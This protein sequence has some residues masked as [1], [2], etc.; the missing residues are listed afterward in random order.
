[1][2]NSGMSGV[3]IKNA[4]SRKLDNSN[5]SILQNAMELDKIYW[6][7]WITDQVNK[8]K[9]H[10]KKSWETLLKKHNNNNEIATKELYDK[11]KLV[12]IKLF[13]KKI[14]EVEN[15]N[16]LRIQKTRESIDKGFINY[17]NYDLKDHEFSQHMQYI[18][19]PSEMDA[20]NKNFMN[21]FHS[22]KPIIK[23]NNSYINKGRDPHIYFI[24]TEE[25]DYWNDKLIEYGL[26]MEKIQ[27]YFNAFKSVSYIKEFLL[28]LGFFQTF[29]NND[30]DFPDR[31]NKKHISFIYYNDNFR[32]S[33]YFKTFAYLKNK[34]DKTSLQC[35][36]YKN[37]LY[38]NLEQL[39]PSE[40][41]NFIARS[42]IIENNTKTKTLTREYLKKNIIDKYTENG[43][44]FD[45]TITTEEIYI[46]RPVEYKAD[47]RYTAAIGSSI[48]ILNFTKGEDDTILQKNI[49]EMIIYI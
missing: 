9:K 41:S 14:T 13:E 37:L 10:Y 25:P 46:V 39:Y 28:R 3:S 35:I 34:F 43:Y 27:P 1:M 2:S 26:E 17:I 21:L 40:I 30:Y 16:K 47:I 45:D 15:R 8:F 11:L 42:I 20:Y 23:S 12:R 31:A 5:N 18:L 29:D 19:D 32:V 4:T 36:G 6:N 7:E 38:I 48:Y 24:I 22:E 49:S 33:T 44:V